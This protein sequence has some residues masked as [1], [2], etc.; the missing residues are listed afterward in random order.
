MPVG[1]CAWFNAKKGFGVIECTD[2]SPMDG[3]PIFVHH[4]NIAMD[5]FKKLV[6]GQTC[7][8]DHSVHKG[9]LVA[10][11]VIPGKACKPNPS[12]TN[13]TNVKEVQRFLHLYHGDMK[14]VD[15][16]DPSPLNVLCCGLSETGFAVVTLE[17]KSLG[18]TRIVGAAHLERGIFPA[19]EQIAEMTKTAR[20]L[21]GRV[22]VDFVYGTRYK[23]LLLTH[24]QMNLDKNQVDY[25]RISEHTHTHSHVMCRVKDRAETMFTEFACRTDVADIRE[26]DIRAT[27]DMLASGYQTPIDERMF[28]TLKSRPSTFETYTRG[29]QYT[30]VI[31][32]IEN[33]CGLK[34]NK[35][36]DETAFAL[37]AE[38]I[39]VQQF[40]RLYH[41]DMKLDV[42][43][44]YPLNV[45]CCGMSETGFAVVTLEDKSLGFNRIVAAAHLVRSIFPALEQIAEMTKTARI[46]AVGRGADVSLVHVDFVYDTRYKGLVLTHKQMNLDQNQVDYHR[47]SEHTHTHSHVMCRANDT[48]KTMFTQF[49]CRPDGA[50]VTESDIRAT[51]DM[52]ASGYQTPIDERMYNTLKCSPSPFK[53]YTSGV[54]Y[55]SVIFAI[56]HYCGL[57]VNKSSDETAFAFNL[58]EECEESPID[59]KETRLC[60]NCFFRHYALCQ[61]CNKYFLIESEGLIDVDEYEDDD[62]YEK[63]LCKKC[64]EEPCELC[65]KAFPLKELSN[66]NNLWVCHECVENTPDNSDNDDDTW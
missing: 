31:F 15:A 61:K 10:D 22:H 1:V 59:H 40:L 32:A 8:Y 52:L 38:H 43:E 24:K 3:S 13:Q 41:G 51:A 4:S 49:A 6:S 25:H 37:N 62:L 12:A 58:C 54:Q 27:A 30:S 57:K 45:M 29:V 36:S 53:T 14:L 63:M 20:A 34:V 42:S 65:H 7:E 55:T 60:F 18:G 2:G 11:N 21:I 16:F 26:S 35:S 33:Y 19:L 64:K 47:I 46:I 17:D 39:E 28:N 23:G 56:E 50:D 5:G 9:R 44:N 48:G 66:Q